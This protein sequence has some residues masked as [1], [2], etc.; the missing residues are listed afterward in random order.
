MSTSPPP[1]ARSW[2]PRASN[3]AGTSSTPASATWRCSPTP[4]ATT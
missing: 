3:S 2:K 4:T 1:P